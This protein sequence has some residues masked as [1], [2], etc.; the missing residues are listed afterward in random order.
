MVGE[1]CD[2]LTY[3]HPTPFSSLMM[4]LKIASQIPSVCLWFWKEQSRPCYNCVFL[5]WPVW[6][7]PEGLM[8]DTCLC[9]VWFRT[10]SGWKSSKGYSLKTLKGKRTSY[11]YF[12][13]KR[14]VIKSY[15]LLNVSFAQVSSFPTVFQYY[16]NC[17]RDSWEWSFDYIS[18]WNRKPLIRFIVA[19][20]LIFIP[21]RP[22]AK[23]YSWGKNQTHSLLR[24]P[25]ERYFGGHL[26]KTFYIY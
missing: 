7:L 20:Y 12:P 9:F 13:P 10:F 24:K 22:G 4:V 5:F 11:C 14:I 2:F 21:W 17:Q 8:Q 3:P 26:L 18:K 23:Y 6:G 19:S 25:G 15:H 16:R 1:H